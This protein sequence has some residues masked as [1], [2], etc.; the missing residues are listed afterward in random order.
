VITIGHDQHGE[1]RQ[2]HRGDAG[3]GQEREDDDREEGPDHVDLAVG[4]VDHA[5]DAVDHAVADRDQAVHGA[6]RQAVD[7]LLKEVVHVLAPGPASPAHRSI[8][9]PPAAG[10]PVP[11]PF[12]LR[13]GRALSMRPAAGGDSVSEPRG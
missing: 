2:R 13:H 9:A 7:E 1:Q 12:E 3:H 10:A 6:Q 11:L 8:L 4:E 5:D